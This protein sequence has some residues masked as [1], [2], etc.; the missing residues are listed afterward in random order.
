MKELS[1]HIL[2]IVQNSIRANANLI[3]I[4]IMEDILENIFKIIIEDNGSGIE[5][6]MLKQ[7]TDPFVTTRTT[8]KV[9]LGLS[10]YQAAAEA[11]GGSLSIR[12]EVGVGTVVEAVFLHN[13]IDRQPLG[14]MTQTMESLIMGNP[15]IDFVYRHKK[16]G[17]EFLLNTVQIRE[18]LGSSVSLDQFE[19]IDWIKE[20]IKEGLAQ[21][22]VN[23]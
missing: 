4:T 7:I 20:Y 9:G 12:S 11:A 22:G 2:D 1:L 8:R 23:E 15:L 19:V 13:H 3:Q 14:D 18:N 16:D 5:E 10:L 21:I 17:A 6:D